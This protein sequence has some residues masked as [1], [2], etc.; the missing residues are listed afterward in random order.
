MT[1]S[2]GQY[3]SK[4]IKAGALIQDAKLTLSNWDEKESISENLTR[5]QEKNIFG[6]ASRKRIQEML[7]IFRERYLENEA[8]RLAL[9]KYVDAKLNDEALRLI[10][11]FHAA[12]VDLLF[13][14][15][16]IEY[17]DQLHSQGGVL[18][19]T[20]DF[21]K[22]LKRWNEEG[23]MTSHWGD[24]TMNRAAR[25]LATT[26]RDFGILQ[27]AVNKRLLSVSVPIAAFAHVAFYMYSH[28]PSGINVLNHPDWKLFFLSTQSVERLFLEAHQYGLLSYYAAGSTIRLTFPANKLEE[29]ADVILQRAT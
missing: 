29:Y 16:V 13:H 3:T 21:A 18:V 12:D 28:N 22:I 19:T 24:V 27:G 4:I 11:F 1:Q 7:R 8:V 15:I 20:D 25:N 9:S 26:L 14:D 10:L 2:N 6:K 17:L 5:L 23:R